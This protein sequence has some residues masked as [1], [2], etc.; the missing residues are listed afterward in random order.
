VPGPA[1]EALEDMAKAHQIFLSAGLI[2]QE[3]T[4]RFKTLVLVGPDGFLGTYQTRRPTPWEVIELHLLPGTQSPVFDLDG[5]VFGMNNCSDSRHG[6][7][8]CD[9]VDQGVE[10]IFS[11]HWNKDS[12]GKSADEWE[13]GKMVYYMK[14]IIQARCHMLLN[15][16]AGSAVM[17]SG[18][19]SI[20]W[21]GAMI[22]D[23]LGQVVSRSARQDNSESM[24]D[25]TIDTEIRKHIPAI[26]L[27]NRH[28]FR[29]WSCFPHVT[30]PG[31][32]SHPWPPGG[33]SSH[34]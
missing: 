26:E 10:L 31:H 25:A 18:N 28:A 2:E 13:W 8:L 24:I 19:L 7:P 22:L 15:N 4:C 29:P 30:P 23:P 20:F 11:P 3:G 14:R 1:I 34:P 16:I 5:I 21:G 27:N 6:E 9:L 17:A 12:L 33:S 32:A